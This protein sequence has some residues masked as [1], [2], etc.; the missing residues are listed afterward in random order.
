[1][2]ESGDAIFWKWRETGGRTQV[3]DTGDVKCKQ[4]LKCKHMIK[5]DSGNTGLFIH[6]GVIGAMSQNIRDN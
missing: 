1:M 3:Q 5:E 4:S 6:K 2:E